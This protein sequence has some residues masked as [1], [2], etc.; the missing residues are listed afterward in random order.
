MPYVGPAAAPIP[1][2]ELVTPA[3]PGQPYTFRRMAQTTVLGLMDAPTITDSHGGI[4]AFGAGG[5]VYIPPA[6]KPAPAPAPAPVAKP[7]APVI[8]QPATVLPPTTGEPL[9]PVVPIITTP[10]V[11]TTQAASEPP[12][13]VPVSSSGSGGAPGVPLPGFNLAPP[14]TTGDQTTAPAAA[15]AGSGLNIT[16]LVTDHPLGALAVVAALAYLLGGHR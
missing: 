5:R 3:V 6:P 15:P 10:P 13:P 7:A 4:L 1:R 9:P 8:A 16:Q 12:Q 11:V 2:A 14:V